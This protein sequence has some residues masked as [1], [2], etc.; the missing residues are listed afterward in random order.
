MMTSQTIRENRALSIADWAEQ[1]A[2]ADAFPCSLWYAKWCTMG[3]TSPPAPLAAG[4]GNAHV[5]HLPVLQ[6]LLPRPESARITD[7]AAWT[8]ITKPSMVYLVN[9]FETQGYVAR[10]ADLIDGRA[11]RV[12]LTERGLEVVHCVCALVE[13]SEAD[14]ECRIGAE[15][16]ADLKSTLRALIASLEVRPAAV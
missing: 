7:L 16:L 8:H 1:L 6:P 11:Q 2:H 5:A 3:A 9:H 10:S 14:W 13:Q 4:Y 15:R 12:R